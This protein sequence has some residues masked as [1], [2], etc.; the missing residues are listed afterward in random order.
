V[1]AAWA[2]QANDMGSCRGE[3]ANMGRMMEVAAA[4]L[5]LA[6]I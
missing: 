5:L 6:F 2:Q 1:L 4:V 3:A